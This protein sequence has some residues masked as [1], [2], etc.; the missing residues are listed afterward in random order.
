M[1]VPNNHLLNRLVLL[2]IR[3]IPKKWCFGFKNEISVSSQL[4]NATQTSATTNIK[5]LIL[6]ALLI[7]SDQ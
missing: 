4:N 1:I 3:F 6:S 2:M 5:Y 7:L